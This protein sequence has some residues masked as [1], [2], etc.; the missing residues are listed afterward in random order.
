MNQRPSLSSPTASLTNIL[1]RWDAALSRRVA[2]S[3]AAASS[4]A[5]GYWLARI[6]AHL[7]DIWLWGLIGYALWHWRVRGRNGKDDV[8]RSGPFWRWVAIATLATVAAGV[9]KRGVRRARPRQVRWLYAPGADALSFPS[10]HAARMGANLLWAGSLLPGGAPLTGTMA[11]LI[12]WSRVRLGVHYVGD[13][14][15]GYA[16]GAAI[17]WG[18]RRLRWQVP[19]TVQAELEHTARW[20]VA[21]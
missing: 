9:A 16:L 8:G 21:F 14:L 5:R 20:L 7:G 6:G 13:V 11:L 1:L 18:W 10:G 19:E 4:R 12:G 2:L 3:P 15:A 17:S